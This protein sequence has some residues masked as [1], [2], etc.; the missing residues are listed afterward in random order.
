MLLFASFFN[1]PVVKRCSFAAPHYLNFL[2]SLDCALH[3]FGFDT[4]NILLESLSILFQFCPLFVIAKALFRVSALFFFY[5]TWFLLCSP[6]FLL[7][8]RIFLL[9]L[10]GMCC[11]DKYTHKECVTNVRSA[12]SIFQCLKHL[13]L[14][15]VRFSIYIRILSLCTVCFCA[16][17]CVCV[18][19]NA[20]D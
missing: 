12:L 15:P 16:N 9:L 3:Q 11:R 19:W 5:F 14:R 2:V 18:L 8:V 6:K 13:W 4:Y 17:V 20:R 7:C 1:F 10:F